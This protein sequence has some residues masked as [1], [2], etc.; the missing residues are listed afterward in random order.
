MHFTSNDAETWFIFA[1]FAKIAKISDNKSFGKTITAL[2]TSWL[3]F[4]N[5]SFSKKNDDFS[6]KSLE[7]QKIEH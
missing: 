1:I 5:S 2:N 4:C 3:K 6:S 7:S